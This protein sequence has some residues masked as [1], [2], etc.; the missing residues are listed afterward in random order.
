MRIVLT[1]PLAYPEFIVGPGV[2]LDLPKLEAEQLL[3]S[4]SAT[5][6]Q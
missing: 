6:G 4:E 1:K 3:A 5:L 2:S